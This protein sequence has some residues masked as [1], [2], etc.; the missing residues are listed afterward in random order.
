[1]GEGK[2]IGKMGREGYMRKKERNKR[3]MEGDGVFI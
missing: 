3:K 2:G 1:M